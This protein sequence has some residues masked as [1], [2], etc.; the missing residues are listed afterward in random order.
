MRLL[1]IINQISLQIKINR[2]AH[3]IRKTAPNITALFFEIK[4]N[5]EEKKYGSTKF[6][7]S[8]SKIY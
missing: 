3:N 5:K 6:A 8:A 7:G 2:Y 1:K 4:K